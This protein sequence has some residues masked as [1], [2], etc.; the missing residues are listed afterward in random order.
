M[1]AHCER[2][3]EAISL[4]LDGMLSSFELALLERHLRG[5]SSCQAFAVAATQQTQL[6]RGAL[7]EEPT[8]P[9]QIPVPSRAIRRSAAGALS[10]CLVA[11]TAAVVLVWPGTRPNPVTVQPQRVGAAVMMVEP[12]EPS[13]ANANVVVP[14]LRLRPASIADG[15]VHGYF[16]AQI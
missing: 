11:A 9:V 2:S 12:A 15:P 8:R 10:A 6:L 3:R 1:S 4:R 7:L 14:R 16:S 13:V 5:C